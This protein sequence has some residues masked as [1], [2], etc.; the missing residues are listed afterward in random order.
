MIG[1]SVN[2]GKARL[3]IH[4]AFD[5]EIAFRRDSRTPERFFNQRKQGRDRLRATD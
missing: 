4:E 1:A 3:A 2:D 5:N